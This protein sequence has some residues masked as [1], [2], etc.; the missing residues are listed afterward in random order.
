MEKQILATLKIDK[1]I[2][3]DVPKHKV[4]ETSVSPEYSNV[5]IELDNALE[6][7]FKKKIVE[8][9][10]ATAS[11]KICFDQNSSSIMP[12]I[13]QSLIYSDIKTLVEY[14]KEAAKELFHSQTGQNP[15]GILVVITAKISNIP[16]IIILK[17]ER[18]EG[19]RLKRDEKKKTFD[20]ES[21]KDLMLTEKT[22]LYKSALFFRRTDFNADFDGFIRDSQIEKYGRTGVAIFFLEKYLGC[23]LYSDSRKQTKEIFDITHEFISK[24]EEPK[25]RVLYYDH[26]ISFFNSNNELISNINI[27]KP[28]G[29]LEELREYLNIIKTIFRN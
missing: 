16:S 17:L 26:L 24:I 1:V 6:S 15:G 7:F 29:S 12:S 27:K 3:H 2:I 5:P 10:S 21:V 14:S 18:D 23:N 20:L 9:I 28:E 19:V 11:F 4:R 25:K 22:R 13:L 8:S